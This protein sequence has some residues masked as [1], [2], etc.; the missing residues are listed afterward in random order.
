M[1][2]ARGA[3]RGDSRAS[4]SRMNGSRDS[5]SRIIQALASKSPVSNSRVDFAVRLGV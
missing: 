4:N 3:A 5:S 1:S 2:A